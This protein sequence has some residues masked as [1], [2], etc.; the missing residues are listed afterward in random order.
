MRGKRLRWVRAGSFRTALR[1]A[2]CDL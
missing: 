1:L 2:Q